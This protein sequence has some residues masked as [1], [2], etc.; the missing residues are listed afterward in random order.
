[1]SVFDFDCIFCGHRSERRWRAETPL[2]KCSNCGHPMKKRPS[3][4]AVHGAMARG[5]ESAVRS[6]DTGKGPG[7]C[8]E[9]PGDSGHGH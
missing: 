1:M 9:S 2:P 5:R 8:C 6:L 7:P 4:P 3:A